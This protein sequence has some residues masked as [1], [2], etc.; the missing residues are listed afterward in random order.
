MIALC[1]LCFLSALAIYTFTATSI[2]HTHV[3]EGGHKHPSG[4]RETCVHDMCIP[5]PFEP[6]S[7]S[8]KQARSDCAGRLACSK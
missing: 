1:L 3:F 2:L 6:F 7:Q 5:E 4:H 8:W